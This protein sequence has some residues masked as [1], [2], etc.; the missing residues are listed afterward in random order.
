MPAIWN[1]YSKSLTARSPQDHAGA[2]GFGEMHEQRVEGPDLDGAIAV[3]VEGLH[4]GLDH[5][6]AIGDGE[7]RPL[8]LI[9]RDPDDEAVD[10]RAARR[11]MSR[12]PVVM[13]SKVPG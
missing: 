3:Q 5:G 10:Q 2:H 4:F 6:D 1:S 7:Q 12:C 13:G 11:M 8:A 9:G